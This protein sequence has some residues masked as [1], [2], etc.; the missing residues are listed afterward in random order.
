MESVVSII[1]YTGEQKCKSKGLL[2]Q[3]NEVNL[4]ENNKDE[5]NAMIKWQIEVLE[6]IR[7]LKK[8]YPDINF[9]KLDKEMRRMPCHF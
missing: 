1:K 6:T 2:T 9:D 4:I 3:N 8:K 5:R 7:K